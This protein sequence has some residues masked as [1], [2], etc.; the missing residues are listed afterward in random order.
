MLFLTKSPTSKGSSLGDLMRK[1][2]MLVFRNFLQ[3]VIQFCS[4]Y[5]DIDLVACCRLTLAGSDA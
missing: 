1:D 4:S 5:M 2:P 3:L